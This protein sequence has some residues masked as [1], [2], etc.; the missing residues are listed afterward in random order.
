MN[1]PMTGGEL[2][3]ETLVSLGVRHIFGVPGG[4]T[5]AI[6]D[7]MIDRDDIDFITARHEGAA[8]VMA[9]AYGRL[10]KTPGVCLATTGP[11][12]TNLLTGVG[13]A[14]RDSSPM[15][16][17]TGN[18]NAENI[19]KDDAQAANHVEIFRP[20]T[21]WSRF[22]T[23]GSSI[24]QAIEEGYINAMTGTMGPVLLD[25]ARD[26]I[27][28]LVAEGPAVRRPHAVQAWVRQQPAADQE[29]LAAAAAKIASA[30]RPVLWVGN[31]ANSKEAADAV[32]TLAQ[33]LQVPVITTFAGIGAVPTRHPLV[34]GPLSRMGTALSTR[35]LA[36]ADLVIAV[37]NSLN[38]VSTFRWHLDLPEIVQLDINPSMIGRYYASRTL[39][40][41]G[42]A[43]AT[44]RALTSLLAGEP[45]VADAVEDR[46]IWLADLQGVAKAWWAE[47]HA[48][49][50]SALSEKPAG[51]LS[52]ADVVCHLRAVTPDETLLIADAGNPGVWSYFWEVRNVGSYLKPVGFGNMGFGVPAAIAAALL[53]P[54]QPVLALVG[55]G[56][57]G[58]SLAELE[59]LARVGGRVVIVVLNDAGYGN[60]RQEQI[61]KY[62]ART[63]GVDFGPVD[64]A[65]VAEGLGVGSHTATGLGQLGRL[66]AAGF[67]A[68][69]PTLIDVPIDPGLSAWTYPLFRPFERS[70]D[71]RHDQH[72]DGQADRQVR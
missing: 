45:Q 32:L 19:E 63:I 2:A 25:F 22:V 59:T 62:G 70:A 16:V 53:K 41:V 28:G 15:L 21:K 44:I 5:L 36:D 31:G 38:S 69:R 9:D 65:K 6:T 49:A 68:A 51:G 37:G 60:I 39:G 14:F 40:V 27:E 3:V 52:P 54:E 34:F 10:T 64:Y 24:R 42:D 67:A 46:R 23:H 71:G 17:I 4:Q 66:V 43:A 72:T 13:G 33:E 18:N 35:V 30:R 8:A 57:L 7:A 48:S 1:G 26:A 58:M 11:G 12:A 29:T 47:A 50:A 56:S 20:L 55:D 61:H